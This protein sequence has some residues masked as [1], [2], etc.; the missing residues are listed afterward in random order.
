M[1][2]AQNQGIERIHELSNPNLMLPKISKTFHGR[3]VF[4]PAAAHLDKGVKPH[5]FGQEIRDPV[6][7]SFAAVEQSGG[8]LNGEVLHIDG[9]GNIITNIKE[10]NMINAKMLNVKFPKVSLKL[11]SGLAYAAAAPKEPIVLVG[12]HGFVEIAVNQASAADEFHVKAGDKIVVS[13][14]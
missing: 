10:K 12:S 14:A 13:S 11:N 5:E 9:F 7:P 2:A 4:A 3:D 6:M 8:A 1:L